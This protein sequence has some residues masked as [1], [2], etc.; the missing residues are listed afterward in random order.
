MHNHN[1]KILDKNEFAFAVRCQC[2][3][4]IQLG[5]GNIALL[6]TV[7]DFQKL[8]RQ[9]EYTYRQMQNTNGCPHRRNILI[10]TSVKN[11]TFMFTFR[12]LSLLLK[13][14]HNTLMMLEVEGI[15]QQK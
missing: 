7:K 1:C 13:M 4:E 9:V 10:D 11:M 14:M 15:L 8:T 5:F 2:H 12:E 3:H 6:M